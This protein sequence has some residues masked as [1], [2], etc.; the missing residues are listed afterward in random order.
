MFET[1]FAELDERIGREGK[2]L[3]PDEWKEAVSWFLPYA[4]ELEEHIPF[5]DVALGEKLLQKS[6]VEYYFNGNQGTGVSFCRVRPENQYYLNRKRKLPQPADP[7]GN[8]ATGIE[9]SLGIYQGVNWGK[10]TRPPEVGLAFQVWGGEE[11]EA[12]RELF[13]DYR[14]MI[15]LMIQSLPGLTFHCAVSFDSVDAYKGKDISRKLWLYLQEDDPESMF[16]LEWAFNSEVSSDVFFRTFRAFAV[17]YLACM[18]R[19]TPRGNKDILL[20]LFSKI[21]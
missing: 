9:I 1:V 15:S 11:R 16:E 6:I 13:F 3:T 14:R 10:G 8:H 4:M 21:K 12:F 18:H 7:K 17:L 20:D 2:E 19:L 5:V